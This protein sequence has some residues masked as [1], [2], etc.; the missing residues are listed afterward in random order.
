[1]SRLNN[2]EQIAHISRQRQRYNEAICRRNADEVCAFLT[3]DYH[4]VTARG[5]QS[6]G[7][8]QQRQRWNTAFAE[9]PVVIYRRR[10]KA[11]RLS[12]QTGAAQ[13]YGYWAGKYSSN[14]KVILTGGVYCAKWL[15]QPDGQWLVQAEIFTMLKS[16]SFALEDD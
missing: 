3:Q 9:D 4:V 12:G 5:T 10:T 7:I 13:E 16:R 6:H 14:Q 15:K 8:E 11:I 2:S 1:M